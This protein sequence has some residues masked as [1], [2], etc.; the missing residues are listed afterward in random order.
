MAVDSARAG[1]CHFYD[2]QRVGQGRVERTVPFMFSADET[3]D[4]GTSR[5]TPVSTDY[6]RRAAVFNGRIDEVE[7]QTGEEAVEAVNPKEQLTIAVARQ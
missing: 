5:G 1:R 6:D 3:M 4:V 2:G 7:V